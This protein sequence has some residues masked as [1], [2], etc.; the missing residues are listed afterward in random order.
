MF[1]QVRDQFLSVWQHQ[2][3]IKRAI[4][5]TL[6]V[7]ASILIPLFVNWAQT[8]NYSVAFSGLSETDAGQ[9]VSKLTEQ[10]VKYQL[11]DSATILVP[12]DQ[13]YEVRLAMARDGL[14]QGTNV[15]FELFSGNTFGMTEFTQRVNYQR[16]LEGEMERTIGSMA[17]VAAVRVHIVTP[18][19]TLLT[20]DQAATT[21]SIT[22]QEKLGQHLDR[23]QVSAITHLVA[24]SVENLKPENVVVVDINGNMLA[25]GQQSGQAAASAESD[26]HRTVEMAASTELQIKVQGLLDSALGPNRSVVQA[27]VVMDWTQRETTTEAYDPARSSIRSSQAVSEVYT[28]TGGT[29]GGIPGAA[30]NLP[31]VSNVN[32]NSSQNS[33]YQRSEQTNNFEIT[34]TKTREVLSPGKIDRISLS[35]LVDGIT[36]TVQL[37]KL[38]TVIAA[39]AGINQTRGDVLAVQSLA[40]D[41]TFYKQQAA[42]MNASQQYDLYITIG[43]AVVGLLVV[44]GLLWYIQ[45]LLS[46]LR[47]ASSQ[48]WTP[49]LKPVG[50]M[51]LPGTT[52]ATYTPGMLPGAGQAGAL[53]LGMM[54]QIEGMPS[55]LPGFAGLEGK[56]GEMPRFGISIPKPELVSEEEEQLKEL[57][58]T[59]AQDN[60]SALAEIIQ[61][62]LNEDEK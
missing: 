13:V 9:I 11:R 26:T 12:S 24:S 10:G 45:R 1:T 16:A 6:V 40:F 35:V 52:G 41:R 30:T 3:P 61:M 4:I 48:A 34:Q 8:P 57:V 21:A 53:G 33:K 32:T 56:E 22:I 49:I 2:S 14:P 19:K 44:I 54:P 50:E 36:D 58:V 38:Q 20:E 25:S 55:A 62:W 47:L 43:A 15:G 59:M 18:E 60:P 27:N 31:P 5:I 39:A 23:S 7:S 46:N 51:A 29:I 17:P 28:T 42:D 37:Q